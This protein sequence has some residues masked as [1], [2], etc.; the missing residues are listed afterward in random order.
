MTK[1]QNGW[2]VVD[3]AK[4]DQGPF[5]GTK[6]PNGILHGPVAAVAVW[7]LR[8]YAATVEPFGPPGCWGYDLK[9]ISGS[10]DYSNHAS[11][12]AWDINAP[13][14]P[15]GVPTAHTFSSTKMTACHAIIS[16]AGGVLR[17]GGDYKGRVDSMHWEI[18]A[19]A[20]AVA[21]FAAKI[22]G[23]DADLALGDVG[24]NVAALQ[25]ALNRVA[26]T[27]PVIDV[28]AIFGAHTDAKV[29]AIQHHFKITADGIAGPV[30]R[31]K[32]GLK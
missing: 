2:P 18:D 25:R 12:T 20:G 6:F 24:E 32:L 11:G 14:H 19:S 3:K 29:R 28:D 9:K 30:T 5:L 16:A 17:W 13:Q 15:M 7:Q 10:S 1:S 26:L 31:G 4:C 27:G 23:S 22:A 21:R 8:R